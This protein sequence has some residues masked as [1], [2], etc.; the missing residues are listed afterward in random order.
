[1]PD[2]FTTIYNAGFPLTWRNLAA[3]AAGF[4]AGFHLADPANPLIPL[5]NQTKVSGG[6]SISAAS[7]TIRS[8]LGSSP[9]ELQDQ[10]SLIFLALLETVTSVQGP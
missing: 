4:E 9:S 5:Y 8:D 7:L 1:L 2:P 10:V 3:G 6:V